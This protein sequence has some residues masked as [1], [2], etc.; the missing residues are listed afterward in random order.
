MSEESN[1]LPPD[2]V[3]SGVDLVKDFAARTS[4]FGSGSSMVRA[5]DGVSLELHRGRTLGLVGESGSGKSTV[6][7]MLLRLVSVSEGKVLLNG[8]DVTDA[9]HTQLRTLRKSM[10]MVFQDPYSSLNPAMRVGEIISEPIA[11]HRSLKRAELAAEVDRILVSV[12]LSPEHA[13]RFPDELSGGQ[14]QR[15]AI[16]RALG[17][18]PQIMVCD[19]AVSAL[20]ISIQS[21]ILNLLLGLQADIGLS[22]LFVS[23]DLS[24]VRHVSHEIAVMYLGHV[25][26]LGPA[27]RVAED[28]AH[29]YT[30]ALLSA[31]PQAKPSTRRDR[32]KIVLAGDP[33]SPSSRPKGCPFASRCPYAFEPCHD[34]RPEHTPIDKGG[35]V[36]CHLQTDG[37]VLSGRTLHGYSPLDLSNSA[38]IVTT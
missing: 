17:P 25:V 34:I 3:L 15:V 32:E 5:V 11:Y 9:R 2:V 19:E 16:A 23:H 4:L 26:E 21:Q 24:V 14:R 6:A 31:V 27:G 22:M 13:R 36:A 38:R 30:Q 7:R 12:G 10:Q 1:A 37:P 33:P 35:T 29:P 28:P 20:D 8:D 18:S